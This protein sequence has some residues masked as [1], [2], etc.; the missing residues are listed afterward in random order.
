MVGSFLRGGK[1]I[2]KITEEQK[3]IISFVVNGLTNIEIGEELGYSS[4]TIKKRLTRLY[5]IF[6]VRNR[7]ELIRK[8]CGI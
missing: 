7:I 5:N 1:L 6:N 2:M 8:S 4:S 3:M